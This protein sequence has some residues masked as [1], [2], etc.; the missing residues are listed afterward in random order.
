MIKLCKKKTTMARTVICCWIEFINEIWHQRNDIT[1][2]N[3]LWKVIGT[4]L[5]LKRFCI[6]MRMFLSDYHKRRIV[7]QYLEGHWS[8]GNSTLILKQ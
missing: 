8:L 4:S 3:P 1:R 2:L 7:I 6:I 5:K